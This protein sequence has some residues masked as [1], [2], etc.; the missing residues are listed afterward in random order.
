MV[1]NLKRAKVVYK[2]SIQDAQLKAKSI[3]QCLECTYSS[4]DELTDDASL[5][6]VLGGDGTLLKCAKYASNFDIPIFGF[7]MGRLGFLAQADFLECDE[8]LYNLQKENYR[9]EERLMLTDFDGHTALNDIVVKNADCSSASVFKLYINSKLV[10]S[11]LADGLI[12]S[13]PTG[14]TA[15]N[16]SAGGAV[17]APEI[18]CM[19]IV[20]IC[21]HTLNARPIVIGADDVIEIKFPYEC[22][23]SVITDGKLAANKKDFVK[24]KKYDKKAKLLLLNS[25]NKEF[26][27]VL[28]DKLHWGVAPGHD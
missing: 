3:A 27:D 8:V 24:I 6:I 26:Y 18:D 28:R 17:I 1:I 14:S 2:K 23:Y 4:I 16:L 19:T 10:C 20:P 13:T 25:E 11:Y 5:F 9:I 12:V 15:Y 22:E 21:A 7:N